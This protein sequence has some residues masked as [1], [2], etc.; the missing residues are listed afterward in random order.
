MQW[1]GAPSGKRGRSQTFSDSAIQFCLTIKCLFGQPLRQSLCMVQSLHKLA[2]LDWPVP[3]FSTACRRQKTLRV[4]P[5]YKRQRS[6]TKPADG[7]RQ[8]MALHAQNIVMI[9]G[10]VGSEI[11]R[12]ANVLVA[13]GMV[14]MN[15][16]VIEFGLLRGT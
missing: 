1:L 3:D 12:P 15:V 16:A 14:H 11:N 10:V 2:Q 4:Q 5:T 6:A 8:Q 9:V 7:W 13:E